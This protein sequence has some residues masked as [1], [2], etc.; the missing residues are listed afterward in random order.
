[1][2]LAAHA[3]EMEAHI[4]LT[5]EALVAANVNPNTYLATD[6][7]NHFNEVEMLIEMLPQ[8]PECVEDVLSWAPKSYPDHFEGSGFNGREV[9]IAAYAAA[10]ESVRRDFDST[11]ERLNEVVQCGQ[12]GLQQVNADKDRLEVL[13]PEL[14]GQIRPLLERARSIVN[15]ANEAPSFSETP[16]DAQSDIDALFS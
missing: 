8:M 3:P 9:V 7:L 2:S 14:V 6:Y 13:A 16:S 5:E 12:A 4:H 15:G 11:I 10:R 1:M